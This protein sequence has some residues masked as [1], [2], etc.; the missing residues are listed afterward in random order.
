LQLGIVIIRGATVKI[1]RVNQDL[2]RLGNLFKLAVD[3]EALDESQAREMISS[4]N[5]IKDE[6]MKKARAL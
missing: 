2:S 6:V 4:I 3:Q 5:E 1:L